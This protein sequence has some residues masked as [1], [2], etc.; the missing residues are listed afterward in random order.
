L[1][2]NK[3][4]QLRFSALTGYAGRGDLNIAL[5]MSSKRQSKAGQG[6]V[7]YDGVAISDDNIPTY[8]D[9]IT[10]LPE[11]HLLGGLT[12]MV[13]ASTRKMELEVELDDYAPHD[14]ITLDR[15]IYL[16]NG[17]KSN[18]HDESATLIIS[19]YGQD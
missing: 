6:T 2:N 12:K 1:D 9:G 18:I 5:S 11:Q 19:S 3:S 14:R 7:Y 16:I 8:A 17:I 4:G 10:E 13:S 15:R